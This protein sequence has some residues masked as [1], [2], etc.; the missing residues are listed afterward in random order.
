[1]E[2]QYLLGAYWGV[3]KLTLREYADMVKAYLQGLQKLHPAFKA[4]S[5]VDDQRDEEHW[6][7]PDLSDLDELLYCNSRHWDEDSRADEFEHL[8]SDGRPTWDTTR[9]LGFREAFYPLDET[10]WT[11]GI[12]LGIT[13]GTYS[14]ALSNVVTIKFPR[15]DHPEFAKAYPDFHS[16]D[17]LKRLL[18]F[19]VNFWHPEAALVRSDSFGDKVDFP[20]R[21]LDNAN[22]NIG[23]LTY[24]ENPAVAAVLPPTIEHEMLDAGGVLI[25]T[26]REAVSATNPEHVSTALQIRDTLHE[27]G[28]LQRKTN[29]ATA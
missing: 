9:R 4:F 24:L 25:T 15:R 7:R 29:H 5:C 11:G 12:D 28:L 16:Y 2:D 23:W 10:V 13:A 14:S 27:R 26:A 20:D 19:T 17:C 8:G 3:R 21:D 18:T 22:W 6:L 1:M